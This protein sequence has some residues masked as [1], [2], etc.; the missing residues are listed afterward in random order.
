[1]PQPSRLAACLVVGILI[2]LLS[3]GG[4]AQQFYTGS[5]N[6]MFRVFGCPG[7]DTLTINGTGPTQQ[8]DCTNFQTG[9]LRGAAVPIEAWVAAQVNGA[10]SALRAQNERL[11]RQVDELT[12]RVQDLEATRGRSRPGGAPN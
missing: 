1:M 5:G 8:G 9:Q 12:S 2:V 10:T 6:N 11:Q 7:L 3:W 4:E